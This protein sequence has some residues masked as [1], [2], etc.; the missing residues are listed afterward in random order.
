M[1]GK[2]GVKGTVGLRGSV[3]LTYKGPDQVTYTGGGKAIAG[4]ELGVSAS[5]SGCNDGQGVKVTACVDP[6][7]FKAEIE[8]SLK[9]GN[10]EYYAKTGYTH[11]LYEGGC[12]PKSGAAVAAL[13]E[14]TFGAEL[15]AA[16]IAKW[17]GYDSPNE[18]VRGLTVGNAPSLPPDASAAQLSDVLAQS[19][20]RNPV[21][22]NHT[23]TV[24]WT[25]PRPAPSPAAD[26]A[27]AAGEEKPV[28]RQNQGG[29]CAQVKLQIEQEAVLTRKAVGAT[30]EIFNEADVPLEELNVTINIYDPQGELAN[31]KFVILAPELNGITRVQGPPPDEVDTNLYVGRELWLQ[32]A[33]STGRARWV[34]LPLDNAAPDEPLVYSVGG[35][36]SYVAG[37]VP[38]TSVLVPGPVTVYPNA[39]LRLKYFHQREVFSDDPFTPETEPSEPFS[40]AVMAQNVGKG[41]AKNFSITSAQPKIIENEKGLLIDF[42]IIATE[43]A[44]QNLSPSLKVSFGDVGPDQIKIGRWLLKASL[45]GFFLDYKASFEHEDRLGGKETSLIES[46]DIHELIHLVE[47]GGTFSDGKPDFLVNDD[48]DEQHLPEWLYLS[49]GQTNEVAAVLAATP[50]GAPSAGDLEVRLTAVMPGGW[51]YLRVPEPGAGEYRLARVVRS[52]GRE[53]AVN[54]NVWVTRYTFVKAG[55]RPVKESRLHLL[56]HDSP[57]SYTLTY[58]VPPVPDAVPPVSGVSGLAAQSPA[59]FAVLWS[60]Q[61]AG[62][63]VSHY[64][65]FVS[66]NG[67]PYLPWLQKTKLNGSLYQGQL[68]SRYAFYSVATDE[69][70]NQ[71]G[72]A[73]G[74]GCAD[75]CDGAE[76]R[77]G[78]GGR[79]EPGDRRRGDVADERGGQ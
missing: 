54:T 68:G 65:L 52:D 22:H 51:A 30:L 63:G 39:R 60:G 1:S 62:S 74:A 67:G 27:V 4:V 70:G 66:V 57:G 42:E 16:G 17:F 78:D 36:F 8:G 15:D 11:Q 5:I 18:M 24:G 26:G 37:G 73:V 69:A 76:Q 45:L 72:G 14:E 56:D 6:I 13:S 34:I 48:K 71:E 21:V 25:P 47:A 29:T 35:A 46:V 58:V 53:I 23:V 12:V 43:V 44:G 49:N 31:D 32:A 61:D 64:D 28:Q 77:A 33:A 75:K 41:L 3:K 19:Q 59:H 38:T 79:G 10:R 7:V 55:Q 50:D 40:L 2:V 20:P 9:V